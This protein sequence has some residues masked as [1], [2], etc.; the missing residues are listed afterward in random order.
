MLTFS[1]FYYNTVLHCIHRFLYFYIILLPLI[2]TAQCHGSIVYLT[3][4]WYFL[5]FFLG[6]CQF[7]L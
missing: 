7:S 2:F 1:I 4:A 5:F 6:F 3:L